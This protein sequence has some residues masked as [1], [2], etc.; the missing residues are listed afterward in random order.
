MPVFAVGVTILYSWSA[1]VTIRES[2]FNWILYFN[3]VDLL[4]LIAYIMAGAFIESLL[5]IIIL[6][7]VGVILP[8]KIFIDKFILRGSILTV[9]FLASTM[10]YYTQTPL[11]EALVDLYKWGVFFVVSSTALLLIAEN[12]PVVRNAIELIA[13]RCLVFLYIY[14]PI[15]FISIIVIIIRNIG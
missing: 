8:R 5:L 4:N 11:G 7:L 15:S 10:Y 9:T 1:I 2:L 6:L 13:D 3:T 14:L 12:I